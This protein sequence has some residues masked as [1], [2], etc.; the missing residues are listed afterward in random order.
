M[1]RRAYTLKGSPSPAK[2]Q[3]EEHDNENDI[4]AAPAVIAEAG[5]HV[6][7]AATEYEDQND[8]D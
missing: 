5:P 1:S 4:E 2:Q 7:A 8:D 6:V 3:I